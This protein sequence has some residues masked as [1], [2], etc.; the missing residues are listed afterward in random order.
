MAQPMTEHHRD[1]SAPTGSAS[2]EARLEV[3]L[4]REQ[5]SLIDRAAATRGT[6]VAEFVRQAVQ[7]AAAQA[8]AEHDLLRLCAEDQEAFA[9]AL[10]APREPSERF[11]AAYADYRERVG[12]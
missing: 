1:S 6:T 11:K 4:T 7:D 10:L 2:R 5:R 12:A 9:A 8:V 3:R